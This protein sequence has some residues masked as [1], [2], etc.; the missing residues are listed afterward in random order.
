ML[1]DRQIPTIIVGEKHFK[2]YVVTTMTSSDH[3]TL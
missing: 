3:V 1:K 2:R